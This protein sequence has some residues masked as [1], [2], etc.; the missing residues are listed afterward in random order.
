MKEEER[1]GLQSHGDFPT[2]KTP[3]PLTVV[4]CTQ[5][6]YTEANTGD[7]RFTEQQQQEARKEK[8]QKSDSAF[9]Y[10]CFSTT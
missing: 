3:N 6:E 2:L 9:P 5:P 8:E 10:F 4:N 1:A 7:F